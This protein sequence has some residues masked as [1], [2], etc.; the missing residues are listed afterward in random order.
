MESEDLAAP[1]SCRVHLGELAGRVGPIL[2]FLICIT[3]VAELADGLGVFATV[4]RAA[5]RLARGSVLGLWLLIVLVAV[6]ATAV[7]SLDTTAVLLTPVVLALARQLD[8]DRAPQTVMAMINS[9]RCGI[10]SAGGRR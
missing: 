7:L 9:P 3:V 5:S 2:G 6:V 10:G 8:L 4:A 1:Y